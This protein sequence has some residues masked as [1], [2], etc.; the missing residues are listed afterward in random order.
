MNKTRRTILE[1]IRGK[2][3]ELNDTLEQLFTDLD[4]ERGEEQ[5]TYDNMSE[6]RQNSERGEAVLAAAEALQNAVDNLDLAR[7]NIEDAINDIG[8][9]IE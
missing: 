5:D 1:K 6:S 8:T 4:G 3:E 2:L 7:T 9:A